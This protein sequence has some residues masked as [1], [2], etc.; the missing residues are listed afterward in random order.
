MSTVTA[1]KAAAELRKLADALDTNPDIEITKP[2]VNFHGYDKATF[3]AVVKL[4][5]RPLAKK[6]DGG[7]ESYRRIRVEYRSEAIEIDAS[8][9]KYLTCELVE[10]AKPAVYR[11]DPLLSLEEIDKVA[12]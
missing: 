8:V 7:D 10:P 2:W 5:P 6:E 12:R 11:C 9:P 1:G 4:L 3:A